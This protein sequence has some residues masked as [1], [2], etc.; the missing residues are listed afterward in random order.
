[1]SINDESTVGGDPDERRASPPATRADD[2]V[3]LEY[4][5]ARDPNDQRARAGTVYS[6]MLLASWLPYLCGVVNASTLAILYTP[7]IIRAHENGAILF[8]GLG[9]AIS[10]IGLIGFIRLRHVP[11]I[12]SAATV[13]AVQ[14]IMAVCAGLAV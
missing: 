5:G 10:A 9:M 4:Y 2:P 6:L 7:P 11:G 1:V 3:R 12:L 13:L 8:M 14:V